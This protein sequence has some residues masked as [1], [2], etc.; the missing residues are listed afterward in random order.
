MDNAD[1]LH[2]ERTVAAR[3]RRGGRAR[4]HARVLGRLRPRPARSARVPGEPDRA[5]WPPTPTCSSCA[6]WA[7]TRPR[8]PVLR[9]HEDRRRA[10]PSR[11][12]S[13]ASCSPSTSTRSSSSSRPRAGWTR[14]RM[15]STNAQGQDRHRPRAAAL[16]AGEQPRRCASCSCSS[17]RRK[18]ELFRASCSSE[19][20]RPSE[21]RTWASCWP[22]SSRPTTPT[23]TAA[24]TSSTTSWP[25]RWSSTGCGWAT[26]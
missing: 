16:R 9:P 23:S 15:A 18:T 22:R 3:R 10:R 12:A 4:R 25:P 20:A 26:P 8:S 17:T 11:R 6:T 1:Q 24:T 2:D 7:P 21:N 5:R 14:S 19:L 13:A